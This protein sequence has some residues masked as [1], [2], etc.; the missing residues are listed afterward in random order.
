MYVNIHVCI[1]S[2]HPPP[3]IAAMKVSFASGKIE[4]K[5]DAAAPDLDGVHYTAVAPDTR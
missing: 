3:T 5:S 1:L 2:V 4:K